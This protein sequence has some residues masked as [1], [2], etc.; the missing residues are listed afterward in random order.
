MV[1]QGQAAAHLM[2]R[3]PWL[4]TTLGAWTTYANVLRMEGG[5]RLQGSMTHLKLSELVRRKLCGNRDA[6]VVI[7]CG[8][9]LRRFR[10]KQALDMRLQKR[11]RFQLSLCL[12]RTFLGKG[13][14][15]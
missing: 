2:C 1:M 11:V 4:G 8:W 6:L 9:V 7:L 10:S 5:H 13:S 14:G 12:S 15:F 3:A